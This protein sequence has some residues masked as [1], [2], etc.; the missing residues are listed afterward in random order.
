M[1]TMIMIRMTIL[2]R[3]VSL[4]LSHDLKEGGVPLEMRLPIVLQMIID[5]C[6]RY[7][8]RYDRAYTREDE[9]NRG[10]RV[11]GA[12][13]MVLEHVVIEAVAVLRPSRI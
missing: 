12:W 11:S 9:E 3:C 4:G 8:C 2:S 13:P 7:N 10:Q 6:S 1:G 5:R